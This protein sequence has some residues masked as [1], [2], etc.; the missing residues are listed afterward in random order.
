[1]HGPAASGGGTDNR[2]S[3]GSPIPIPL[4]EADKR[5]GKDEQSPNTVRD[6]DV[7]DE[8]EMDHAQLQTRHVKLN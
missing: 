2:A 3:T 6:A 1:M 4:D 7:P 5:D 8:E